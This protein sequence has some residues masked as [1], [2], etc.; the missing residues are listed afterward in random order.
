MQVWFPQAVSKILIIS[1]VYLKKEGGEKGRKG[2]RWGE[3]WKERE[4]EREEEEKEK[5]RKFYLRTGH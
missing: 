3:G 4:R 2:K 1:V 5:N